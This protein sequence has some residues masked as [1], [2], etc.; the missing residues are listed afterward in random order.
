MKKEK[1]L[2][3]RLTEKE[4]M[5]LKNIAEKK[6]KMTISD[7]IRYQ[8]FFEINILNLIEVLKKEGLTQKSIEKF[9]DINF[10]LTKLYTEAI[11]PLRRL[12]E[13]LN[14]NQNKII[15]KIGGKKI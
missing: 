15:T 7:Y 12:F 4:F 3:F 5:Y 8:G 13:K 1:R 11:D 10:H 6:F 9:Y 14:E 2:E